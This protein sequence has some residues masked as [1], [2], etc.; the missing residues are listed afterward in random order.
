MSTGGTDTATERAGAA[1]S[2]GQGASLDQLRLLW[3][4]RWIILA[5]V[6][7]AVCLDA[8]WVLRQ[9]KVYAASA[10]VQ[11]D[12]NPPRPL[13]R[14]VDDIDTPGA[15]SYWNVREYYETQYRVAR[16]RGVAE[17]VVRRLGLQHDPDFLH[18]RP[19][20]RASFRSVSVS[21][22]AMALT[23]R[24][25]I[26]PVKESRLMNVI[27]EDRSP[28]RAQL[29]ANTLA[30]VYIQRN[31]DSRLGATRDAVRWLS[32]QLDD[33]RTNLSRSED[34]IQTFRREH[35]IVAENFTDHRN[36]LGNR[37]GRLS[38]ALTETQTR[39]FALAA[40]V[41]EIQRVEREVQ[42]TLRDNGP[43][44]D[45]G[46]TVEE[47]GAWHRNV[48]EAMSQLTAPEFLGSAVLSGLRTQFETAGRE[49][50]ALE[51]RY[52]PR[53]LELRTARARTN[54]VV[55]MFRAEVRNIAGS[56]EAELRAVTRAEGSV[57]SELA[58]AQRQAV[59]LNQQEMLYARLSR[60][61]ENHAKLYGIVLERA[62]EGNLMRD[63][64]VN[65]IS[66]L[67]Y[68]LQPGA[69][70]KPRVAMNLGVGAAGGLVLGVLAALLAIQSDRTVRSRQDIEEIL[71][72]TCLGY[73][74]SVTGRGMRNQYK[75]QYG[76]TPQNSGP[77]ENID[78]MAHTHPT[79]MAAE[80]ARGI[81][82]NLLFSNPDKPYTAIM[83]SSS[84]PREGKTFTAVTLA[85]TLAQSGKRVLL[86]DCDLRRPRVHKVFGLRPPVGVTS[87]L[88]EEATLDEATIET[89]VPNLSILPCGPLP[90]N[91]AELLHSQ[92]F[93]DLVEVLRGKYDRLIFDSP[94]V[95]AV[96]DALALGPHLDGLVLVLRARSSRRDNASDVL[97]QFRT[98]GTK[99]IGCVLNAVDLR[100]ESPAYYYGR[101]DYSA[102][103][104]NG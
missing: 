8:L 59:E 93:L 82:T 52:L 15:G 23:A 31:L 25:R 27:V 92:K 30:D 97:R 74:P 50:A 67:D 69:P 49:E 7:V 47:R 13:G 2:E 101:Y 12:P 18:V 35:N 33:L 98:L 22:A 83:V 72:A 5:G 51:P 19:E 14:R 94:P 85:I 26:E 58:L 90:P 3:K 66:V 10:T 53:A 40:R 43:G 60:E 48:S 89:E 100:D 55:A 6:A 36:V 1:T 81:R 63:L 46:A 80:M 99:V 42:R 104:D 11:F 79:S 76:D 61:R 38:D 24:V 87:V 64:Q 95:N 78:L 4:H 34:A 20:Q 9:P 44:F 21:D 75:Y 77:I 102:R 29:L 71:R 96:N 45:L 17:G 62:T 57:R 32:N 73:L 54:N 70:I 16:S 84:S 39:R 37:I 86:V 68:A 56:A 103:P 91:P 28:R 41:S 65:N 88:I